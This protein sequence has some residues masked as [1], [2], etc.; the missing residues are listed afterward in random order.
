VG[1][2]AASDCSQLLTM[3]LPV[4]DSFFDCVMFGIL[5]DFLDINARD[6]RDMVNCWLV[7]GCCLTVC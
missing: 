6:Q 4:A 2:G 5:G 3:I 1:C 7:V